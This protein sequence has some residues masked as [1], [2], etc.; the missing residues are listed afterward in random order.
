MYCYYTEVDVSQVPQGE[1]L[2]TDC[3][4]KQLIQTVEHCSAVY[5]SGNVG[6]HSHTLI[7]CGGG[8][9]L[10]FIVKPV[11]YPILVCH[12]HS[13]HILA[14]CCFVGWLGESLFVFLKQ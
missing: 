13:K 12:L 2:P 7:E 8:V 9:L 10:H 1:Q 5:M 6:N 11:Y 14:G 4:T 3:N